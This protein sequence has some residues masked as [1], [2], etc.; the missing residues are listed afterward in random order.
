VPN[1]ALCSE[2]RCPTA[3]AGNS[4]FCKWSGVSSANP[5]CEPVYTVNPCQ[6]GGA[7]CGKPGTRY[8]NCQVK[9]QAEPQRCVVNARCTDKST[10][11]S[12]SQADQDACNNIVAGPAK[13]PVCVA[14]VR[15][16]L[17]MNCYA[18]G[19]DPCGDGGENCAVP[20]TP[21]ENCKLVGWP[22]R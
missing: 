7:E 5:Y 9:E 22:V 18:N 13:T 17:G 1:W 19:S 8:S 3:G 2:R 21:Y 11:F 12:T 10:S 20:G 14:Q 4:S 6:G 15:R 16:W